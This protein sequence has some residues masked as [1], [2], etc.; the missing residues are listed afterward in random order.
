MKVS[1]KSLELNIGAE[2]LGVMRNVLGMPK[3]YLRGLTQREEKQE[4][5]DFFAQ[6]DPATRLFAFQFKAPIGNVDT[7][8]YRYTLVRDQHNA[9]F[10]LAQ[11]SPNSVFYVLPF[12][13]T[14][15]KLQQDVPFL[16][17]DT[18]LLA[19]EDMPGPQIFGTTQSKVVQCQPGLA[20]VNPEYRLLPL[21]EVSLNRMVG[22]PAR[23]FAE[24]YLHYRDLGG[25]A[26]RRRSP[27]LARGLRVAVVLP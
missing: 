27:W 12:Y 15:A 7:P 14:V 10:W 9:L 22:V 11:S 4:G 19:V 23:Q 1:E 18:W 17:Q 2:L 21:L 3:A 20:T 8:P 6:L 5:V 26:E 13:V 25:V 16:M 24:W